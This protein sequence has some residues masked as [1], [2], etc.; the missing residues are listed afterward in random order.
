[1][2][3]ARVTS[4]LLIEHQTPNQPDEV[5]PAGQKAAMQGVVNGHAYSVL[6]VYEGHD[7]RL[8]QLRNPWG[9]C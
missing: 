5:D 1:V 4:V 6:H 2:G 9:V 7:L 8:L 3:G